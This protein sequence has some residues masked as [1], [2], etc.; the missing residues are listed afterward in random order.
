[1]KRL[2]GVQILQ[3]TNRSTNL[4]KLEYNLRHQL[5]E[6]LYHEEIFWFQKSKEEWIVLGDRNTRFYHLSIKIKNNRLAMNSLKNGDG[7]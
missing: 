5:H 4:A 3:A 7:V 1:M 6:V 2:K